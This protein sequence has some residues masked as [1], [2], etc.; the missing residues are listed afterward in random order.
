MICEKC[1]RDAWDFGYFG[2]CETQTERYYKLLQ[3]L[4]SNPCDVEKKIKKS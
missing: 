3:E 1:W 4:K 2:G